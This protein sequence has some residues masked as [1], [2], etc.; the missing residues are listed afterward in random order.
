MKIL[1]DECWYNSVDEESGEAFCDLSMYEDEYAKML[2]DPQKEKSC[3]YF[4]P[5]IGEY[6]IVRKQN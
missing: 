5:D 2:A 6:G 4:R 3:R 1:C